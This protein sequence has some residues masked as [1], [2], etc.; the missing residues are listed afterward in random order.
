M[1]VLPFDEVQKNLQ[2]RLVEIK[3]AFDLFEGHFI[4][5]AY[6]NVARNRSFT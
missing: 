1:G 4:F 3:K 5:G 6:G 2:R